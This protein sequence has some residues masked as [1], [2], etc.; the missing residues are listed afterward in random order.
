[1]NAPL[2]DAQQKAKILQSGGC[3]TGL[4]NHAYTSEA[5]F[6]WE[7]ENLFANTWTCIGSSCEVLDAGAVKPVG[8][9]GAP[10]LMIR[11]NSNNVKVFHNVCSHRGN[12]LVWKACQ[13][14]GMISC[15]YHG[16]TY[17]LAGQLRGTPHVGGTGVHE[18]DG[19]DKS[20]HGLRE[21]RSAEW[22]G[23]VFVNLS[24]NAPSFETLIAPL[25]Q[26]VDKLAEREQFS[27]LKDAVSHGKLTI[28]FEGNWK[29]CVENNLESYHLPWVHPGLNAV[30]RLEDHYHFYHDDYFA[31]QGSR[32]YDHTKIHEKYFPMFSQWPEKVAEYP[33]LYPNVFLGLHCDHYWTRI[34][35]PVSPTLTRD[36]LQ[37]YYLGDAAHSPDYEEE[38]KVR[39]DTWAEVFYEDIGVV[40]GMQRGRNSPAFNGGVFTPLMDEPSHHFARWVTKQL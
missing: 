35:E 40:K 14:N 33:T 21:A 4:P 7:R 38:R 36:H 29:L 16:W 39:M 32:E 24:E 17:D 13:T 1:M 18:I 10:L 6:Q 3:T 11:D 2:I 26:R 12:E 20:K 22:M 37:I 8:F 27:D 30:S 19:L 15:P 28:E 5:F 23:L 34:V 25:Q 9:L 31:G